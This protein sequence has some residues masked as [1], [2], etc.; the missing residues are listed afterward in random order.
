M[1]GLLAFAI[2]VFVFLQAPAFAGDAGTWIDL[3]T[4]FAVIGAAAYALRG[5]ARWVL[6]LAVVAGILFVDGHGIHLSANDIGHY[7]TIT[8]KAED[9]RHFWDE[10]FGH[11][12]WH[13]GLIALLA[14]LALAD[15]RRGRP[16]AL[17]WVAAVLLG[18]ALFTGTVEGG[19]W[20]VTLIAAAL[21]GGLFLA[22]RSRTLVACASGAF[23]GAALIGVWAVWQGGVPQFSELGW[24]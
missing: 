2:A 3:A 13:A 22:H 11:I 18:W 24:F 23:L 9:V 5:A 6:A 7:D 19:D 8:G 10:A 12:Y 20:W 1:K 14:V 17:G 16:D 21:L 15:R 4:P